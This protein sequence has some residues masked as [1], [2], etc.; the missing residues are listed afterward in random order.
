MLITEN[1]M[2]IFILTVFWTILLNTVSSQ[3]ICQYTVQITN[4]PPC[5]T[6][7]NGSITVGNVTYT[8]QPPPTVSY[9]LITP[10]TVVIQ[11]GGW[12]YWSGLCNGIY[13][14]AIKFNNGG[15]TTNCG[16][17]CQIIWGYGSPPTKLNEISQDNF[18]SLK[19]FP[20]PGNDFVI[21]ELSDKFSETI[22]SIQILNNLGQIIREE[23]IF[24][25]KNIA[26]IKTDNLATGIYSLRLKINEQTINKR[27]IL[28]R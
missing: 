15:D 19:V 13:T 17:T 14:V 24:F 1:E 26:T 16:V 25:S 8:C 23:E 2:K 22:S 9:A 11:W 18:S 10:T 3:T 27:L 28:D 5:T 7:C 12:A 20:N 21:L 6:C 4:P